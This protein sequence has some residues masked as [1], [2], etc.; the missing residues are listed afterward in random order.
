MN[1]VEPSLEGHRCLL[2][3]GG[4]TNSG[5]QT[6]FQAVVQA[7]AC[8][9]VICPRSFTTAGPNTHS[10]S[11]IFSLYNVRSAAKRPKQVSDI[12]KQPLAPSRRLLL[13]HHPPFRQ[14]FHVLR[15][16]VHPGYEVAVEEREGRLRVL[17][18]IA[19]CMFPAGTGHNPLC[20]PQRGSSMTT[21]LRD[22]PRNA[23]TT[24]MKLEY[25]NEQCPWLHGCCRVLEM[26]PLK[27]R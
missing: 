27:A 4:Q 18:E 15:K 7:R 19:S 8:W 20:T 22:G 16:C 12:A 1:A 21:G 26:L 9:D 11:A 13:I 17:V 2:V 24:L 5:L 6:K 14:I 3:I 25:S 23:H 10:Q